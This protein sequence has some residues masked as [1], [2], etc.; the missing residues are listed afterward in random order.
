[1]IIFNDAWLKIFNIAS[2][3]HWWCEIRFFSEVLH[4]TN[5]GTQISAPQTHVITQTSGTEDGCVVT[6]ESKRYSSYACEV[7]KGAAVWSNSILLALFYWAK[8]TQLSNT[9]SKELNWV[10]F[11][12]TNRM[13]ELLYKI[14]I[15]CIHIWKENTKLVP[16]QIY[17]YTVVQDSF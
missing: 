9:I 16:K 4:L 15:T 3:S 7:N 2:C 11:R 8:G 12:N 17:R 6:A 5:S 10:L 14:A 13:K 1:M